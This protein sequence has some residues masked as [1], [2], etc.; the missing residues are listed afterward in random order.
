MGAKRHATDNQRVIDYARV[1]P[2]CKPSRRFSV[3]FILALAV[4][5]FAV[6][7]ALLVYQCA[8]ATDRVFVIMDVI[9]ASL[10]AR[11]L[12]SIVLASAALL[13]C[14]RPSLR[15]AR[16]YIALVLFLCSLPMAM[17]LTRF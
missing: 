16:V 8:G 13:M 15:C 5:N 7:A 11:Q 1:N 17:T 14:L 4:V 10:R 3:R 12:I 2:P 9:L 6:N